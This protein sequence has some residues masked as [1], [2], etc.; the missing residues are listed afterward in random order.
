[1]LIFV[2]KSLSFLARKNTLDGRSLLETMKVA[3]L[4]WSLVDITDIS[5]IHTLQQLGLT[6]P[7]AYASHMQCIG[8]VHSH[9]WTVMQHGQ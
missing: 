9:H 4:Q 5:S 3:P 6:I 7:K 1:M 2:K 8:K